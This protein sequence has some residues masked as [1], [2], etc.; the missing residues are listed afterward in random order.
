[1]NFKRKTILSIFLFSF[2]V[3]GALTSLFFYN[4]NNKS[5]NRTPSNISQV[6]DL[7]ESTL[8]IFKQLFLSNLATFNLNQ[9]SYLQFNTRYS[10]PFFKN[11]HLCES[12]PKII[13]IF[14]AEGI[15]HSGAKP[16]FE[17]ESPCLTLNSHPTLGQSAEIPLNQLLKKSISFE[18]NIFEFKDQKS[19]QALLRF[20][21]TNVSLENNSASDL[22]TSLPTDWALVGVLFENT[23][24][25]TDIEISL[26]DIIQNRPKPLGFFWNQ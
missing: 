1:M 17:F 8:Q 10:L 6:E 11:Q 3:I 14:Q 19:N 9:T 15:A 20:F 13:F 5:F 2:V 26:N 4:S 24:E 16:R 23:Q 25:Q 18:N 22:Q 21:N 12:H 7:D